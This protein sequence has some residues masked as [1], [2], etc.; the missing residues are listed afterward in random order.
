MALFFNNAISK[1]EHALGLFKDILFLK[2][3][4][5]V[6]QKRIKFDQSLNRF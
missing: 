6:T 4:Q 3:H 1:N 2:G 5:V